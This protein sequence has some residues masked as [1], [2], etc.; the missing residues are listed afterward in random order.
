MLAPAEAAFRLADTASLTLLGLG[1]KMGVPLHVVKPPQSPA[2]E[3]LAGAIR[4][5]A[6]ASAELERASKP[7]DR[8]QNL[9]AAHDRAVRALAEAREADTAELGAWLA[10][11]R[12]GDRPGMSDATREAERA[13][14]ELEVDAAAARLALPAKATERAQA[15][16]QL[17]TAQHHRDECLAVAAHDAA[18][19]VVNTEL[20]AALEDV[21]RVEVKLRG[22]MVALG[23][24]AN[25]SQAPIPVAGGIA[26]QIGDEIAAARRDA[27]I[28][29]DDVYG[30]T[31]F[32]KLASDPE[33]RL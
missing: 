12:D 17:M 14:R 7:A 19:D 20:K 13:V 24:A 30:R 16:A 25:R 5:L 18:R 3:A 29:R 28:A 33:A 2:R 31:F 1:L 11:G 22:L 6:A 21:L 8:L 27:A 10:E 9:I 32:D 4:S 15:H 26:A 23:E